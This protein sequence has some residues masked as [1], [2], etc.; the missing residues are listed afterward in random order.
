MYWRP[1]GSI[2]PDDRGSIDVL[3]VP[4]STG[5]P[6]HL[7][8]PA[9]REQE[10]AMAKTQKHGNQ[11]ARKPEANKSPSVAATPSLPTGGALPPISLPK[12]KR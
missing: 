3:G 8:A 12:K 7:A 5:T 4:V 10:T 2:W 1:D 11:E 9:N 6:F